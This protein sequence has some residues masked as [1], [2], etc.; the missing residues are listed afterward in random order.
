MLEVSS[1]DLGGGLFAGGLFY[2]RETPLLTFLAL[3]A[4]RFLVTDLLPPLLDHCLLT[5]I[6]HYLT[7][8][9]S[10]S[11]LFLR[12]RFPASGPLAERLQE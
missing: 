5:E 6:S 4:S 8:N 3:L 12:P 1:N 11:E 2:L 10:S 9:S 7:M